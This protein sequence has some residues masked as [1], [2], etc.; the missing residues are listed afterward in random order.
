MSKEAKKHEFQ[1]DVSRLLD[2]VANA[3][4]SERDVFLR[5]L[6]SNASDAC[7]KRRYLALQDA[8][9]GLGDDESYEITLCADNDKKQLVIKDRGI[10]MNEQDL[11]DNLGTIARS[12][13]AAFVEQLKEKQEDDKGSLIGQFGV[14]F[15][16]SFMVADYVEVVSKKAG[17]DQAYKWMSDGRSGYEIE[18]CEKDTVGTD[19]YLHLKEDAYTFLE[20]SPLAQTVMRY[21]D[22][23]DFPIL[24]EKEEGETERLNQGTALWARPKSEI[25][26][27]EY[28]QFYTHIGAGYDIPTKT[29]HW[30]VEGLMD[31]TGLLYIPS[32]R[33]Y[34]LFD[35]KR[36]H[37]VKLYVKRVYITDHCEG[38]VP[39][40]LR[41]LRG[42]V[43]SQDLPLNISREM[44]QTN[45]MVSK[46]SQGITKK[47]LKEL[48][49]LREDEQLY[50]PF[51]KNY[52]SV[53]KEGLYE[54]G[55]HREK[56]LE[57]SLFNTTNDDDFTSLDGYVERMKEGQ[58]EIYYLQGDNIE[59][60]RQSPQLEA[61]LD[62]GI[63]VLLLDHVIDSFWV[64]AM[65]VYKEIAF[66]SITQ[67]GVDLSAFS[68]DEKETKEDTS[69]SEKQQDDYSA[70]LE[71]MNETLKGLV[72]E[73]KVSTR[74]SRSP[75][76]LIADKADADLAMEKLL[77]QHQNASASGLRILEINPNHVLLQKIKSRFETGQD[78][79]YV[80][81]ATYM[82]YDQARM[83]EGE[84]PHD[85]TAFTNRLNS[86]LSK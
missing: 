3:L 31:Y 17:E 2:I 7:D 84:F 8:S 79:G 83:I 13:T 12:G 35:P 51:W 37:G 45:P 76:C 69:A 14:G 72:K 57:L 23:I 9:L 74:L 80:T 32:I 50:L 64:P 48:E 68:S 38:L 66:K 86:I 75:V 15:Y 71:A 67:D 28:Q 81:D 4:Y 34:D 1:S 26:D 36:P 43:D 65:G 73:V 62:K 61:F 77:K 42:V 52:G 33:P 53:L 59:A 58:K 5:E 6:I 70:L 55:A 60:M 21:S 27:E 85:I 47:I 29:F 39:H 24:F 11:V 30:R 49:I 25:T 40:W 54:V 78:D 18:L 10:G 82:L 22:H 16:A 41:F 20:K 46:I 19:I 44:L 56:I 63:E